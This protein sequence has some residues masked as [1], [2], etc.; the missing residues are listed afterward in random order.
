MTCYDVGLSDASNSSECD[1]RGLPP[2]WAVVGVPLA[3]H[4]L[5]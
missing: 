4:A 5:L 3:F 1:T 2:D